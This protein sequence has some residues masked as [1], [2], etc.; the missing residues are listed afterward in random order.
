MKW[1]PTSL[2]T[3][4]QNTAIRLTEYLY[5]NVH[6][7]LIICAWLMYIRKCCLHVYIHVFVCIVVVNSR[8][9][10]LYVLVACGI[11]T[12]LLKWWHAV[13]MDWSSSGTN[14]YLQQSINTHTLCTHLWCMLM[15]VMFKQILHVMTKLKKN[16]GMG[17][18]CHDMSCV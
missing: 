5:N 10:I 9:M 12:R 11:L 18:W 3:T 4:L 6:W 17:V 16:K 15:Y 13:G 8:H 7:K 1:Q 2:F 14:T